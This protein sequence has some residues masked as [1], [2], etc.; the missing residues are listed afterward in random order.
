MSGDPNKNGEA[1]YLANILGN[2][3]VIGYGLALYQQ[4]WWSL[5]IAVIATICGYLLARRLL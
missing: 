5:L 1:R 4:K 3:A 2:I